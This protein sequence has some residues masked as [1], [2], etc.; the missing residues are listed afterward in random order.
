MAEKIISHLE[1]A[2]SRIEEKFSEAGTFLQ[3]ALTLINQQLEVLGNLTTVLDPESILGA[4]QDLM[5]V[6]QCLY[7]LPQDLDA[8]GSRLRT[9][10]REGQA[11]RPQINEIYGLLRYLRAFA[12]NVKITAAG[13]GDDAQQFSSFSQEMGTRI[14]HGDKQIRA[15]IADLSALDLQIDTALKSEAALHGQVQAMLPQVPQRLSNDASS[16]RDYN[17][18]VA[19]ATQRIAALAKDVQMS[20]LTALSSLQIGDTVRQRIE[21]VQTGLAALQTLMDR[22]HEQGIPEDC[23]QRLRS[24]VESLLT[25]QLADT[26]ETFDAEAARMMDLM[27]QIADGTNKLVLAFDIEHGDDNSLRG[28]EQ[29][30]AQAFLLVE[31]MDRAA[32][33]ANAVQTATGNAVRDLLERVGGVREVKDEVQYMALNTSLRCVHIGETGRPLQVVAN[34]LS[35]YS[36]MLDAAAMTTLKGVE[37]L[38]E[39][40]AQEEPNA[41]RSNQAQKLEGAAQRLRK[42][43]DV[44]EIDLR[45]AITQGQSLVGKLGSATEKL[46]FKATLVDIVYESASLLGAECKQDVNVADISAPL[47]EILGM[48]DKSYTMARERQVHAQ[49]LPEGHT[50]IAFEETPKSDSD[51][52][53]EM[54]G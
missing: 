7:D 28:L 13:M 50:A 31:G 20:V 45:Q 4:T 3:D 14:D 33:Q 41:S 21:H 35:T 15:F 37:R 48:I 54:F 44:V 52:D 42:A 26:A 27:T 16:M 40:A 32:E 29:S 22:M 2:R 46:N 38:A 17:K 39:K 51:D 30:V 43:A 10:R 49:F 24:H 11:L 34:E 8:R 25:A 6:A 1:T 18:R 9:L 12:L 23:R 5:S 19:D 36:K 53:F 47:A